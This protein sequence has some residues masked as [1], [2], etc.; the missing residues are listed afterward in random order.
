[1]TTFGGFSFDESPFAGI[2]LLSSR[3]VGQTRQQ[4]PNTGR[5]GTPQPNNPGANR[6]NTGN[7][8]SN[9]GTQRP[10]GQGPAGAA[11]K[12]PPAPAPKKVSE[13]DKRKERARALFADAANAQN[14]GAYPLA[15]EQWTKLIKEFPTDPLASSARYYLGL[16]YQEQE[17]P[18]YNNAVATFRKALEDKNLKEQEEA[19]LNLG[20]C[21]VQLGTL[22]DSQSEPKGIFS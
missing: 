22:E 2:D 21:L 7:P 20:W 14:N 17:T 4:P 15:M 18:D 19:M 10:A 12:N 13:E 5:P 3:C 16:C 8:R 6:G 1:M 9:P 11:A